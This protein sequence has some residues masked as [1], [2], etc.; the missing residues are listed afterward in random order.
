MSVAA[1]LVAALAY[2][3]LAAVKRKPPPMSQI[4]FASLFAVTTCEAAY[5]QPR[6]G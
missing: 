4:S 1:P 3:R 5:D 2:A 6:P